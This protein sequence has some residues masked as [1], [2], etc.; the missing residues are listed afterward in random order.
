MQIRLGNEMN[1][2]QKWTL[3]K[4]RL[5]GSSSMVGKYGIAVNLPNVL[6]GILMQHT[7][8]HVFE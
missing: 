1:D 6:I 8:K 7:L 2:I 5:K 4:H 3:K